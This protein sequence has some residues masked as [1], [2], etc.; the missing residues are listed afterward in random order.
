M[1]TQL[2]TLT[3]TLTLLCKAINQDNFHHFMTIT[4]LACG[5]H[6]YGIMNGVQAR[7]NTGDELMR[8]VDPEGT[9][10][11]RLQVIHAF[12]VVEL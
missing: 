9:L 2:S 5:C 4:L 1:Y 10:A 6:Q 8:R 3:L 12:N 7:C 11:R